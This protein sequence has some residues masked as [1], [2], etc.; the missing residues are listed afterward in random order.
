MI[1]DTLGEVA[2]LYEQ[3]DFVF[4]GG[5]LAEAGGH[6]IIEPASKG[7]PVV[8]TGFRGESV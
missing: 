7:K 8:L 5:S 3:A 6:N 2:S 1:L 4:V